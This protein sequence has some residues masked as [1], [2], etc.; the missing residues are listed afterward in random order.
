MGT[1]LRTS[2]RG[3]WV[4]AGMRRP[5]KVVSPGSVVV[6]WVARNE[7]AQE[8][9]RCDMYSC[10][11]QVTRN[12]DPFHKVTEPH[13]DSESQNMEVY[14]PPKIST[15]PPSFPAGYFGAET[16]KPKT[17]GTNRTCHLF[18][19]ISPCLETFTPFP[20][21]FSTQRPTATAHAFSA[22]RSFLRALQQPFARTLATVA[23]ASS[24]TAPAST[25][26]APGKWTPQTLRTG[27]I[28]R[29]RGMTA[30]WDADGRRW[31]VTVLQVDANQVVRHSPPP[32]TSPYHTL[33]IG[34]SPRREKTTTKQLLG[35]FRK[36]GVEPKYR[37]KEFQVS[38]NA[39]VPVGTELSA[40]HFVPGQ[41]V[42]VQGATYV[43]FGSLFVRNPLREPLN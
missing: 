43:F 36:A 25:P 6:Q 23:E 5:V 19:E 28:A 1:V 18:V 9:P 30:L 15:T 32:P 24:S 39:V 22:M 16:A 14:L 3:D 11:S 42:D 13:Q 26:S 20:L 35:H 10:G 31:P 2:A 21:A 7:E 4:F 40:G 33:Q 38:E 27:L 17:H 41:F 34:A 12:E 29:K 8:G 37:L